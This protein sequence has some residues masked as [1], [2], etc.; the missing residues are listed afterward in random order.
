MKPRVS[1]RLAEVVDELRF[2][3]KVIVEND[4]NERTGLRHLRSEV[5]LQKVRRKTNTR[6]K[7]EGKPCG[8]TNT[9]VASFSFEVDHHG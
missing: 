3:R 6:A 4:V 9:H 5:T 8:I 7:C 1:A 2:K